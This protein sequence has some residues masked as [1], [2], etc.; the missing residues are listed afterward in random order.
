ME[1]EQMSYN[2]FL[3]EIKMAIQK[4]LRDSYEIQIQQI[5]KNNGLKI[6]TGL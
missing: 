5:R 4:R 3:E 1:E 6:D 2:Q